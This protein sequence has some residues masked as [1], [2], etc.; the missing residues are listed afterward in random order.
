MEAGIVLHDADSQWRPCLPSL[1]FFGGAW[2]WVLF[3]HS[4]FPVLLFGQLRPRV[5]IQGP[6][7]PAPFP[8]E[9]GVRVLYRRLKLM[10]DCCLVVLGSRTVLKSVIGSLGVFTFVVAVLNF[11]EGV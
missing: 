10:E 3:N 7:I 2:V 4:S 9:R 6:W 8:L 5:P 11:W 1:F